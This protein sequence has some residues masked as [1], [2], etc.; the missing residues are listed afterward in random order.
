MKYTPITSLKDDICEAPL[1]F[2]MGYFPI[3]A[4]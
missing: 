4:A 1:Q 2:E 3:H